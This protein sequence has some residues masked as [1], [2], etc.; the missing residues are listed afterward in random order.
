[1]VIYNYKK[2]K[3][4]KHLI[5]IL[6]M[7]ILALM[8]YSCQTD[9]VTN[10]DLNKPVTITKFSVG[11]AD[12]TINE[13]TKTIK[14]IVPDGSDVTKISPVVVLPQGAVITPAITSNMDFTAPI[15]FTIVNGDVY[16]KY[17][18]SVT[19]QFFIG[20]L[21]TASTVDGIT[22]DDEKAAAAWFLK[23]YE[24]G[25]YVS[26][27]DI[28]NAKVD[29]N[30]YRVLWWYYDTSKDLP[31]I[32]KDPVVLNSINTY[33]KNG[34]NLLLN[35]Y[36]CSYFWDLGRIQTNYPRGID[37]GA[38]FDNPDAWGIG[39]NI[40]SHN[41]T[42]HP[43]YN[44][45]TF[46]VDGDG[47]HWVPVIGPGWKENHNYVIVDIPN[48]VNLSPNNNEAVYDAFTTA[49]K[50][51]WLGVWSGIR[52]YWMAGVMELSPTT[53]YKGKAIF[54]GIGG[55]EFNQNLSGTIN[56]SG[57]N[58]FQSNIN[59]MTKNSLDYLSIKN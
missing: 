12:G 35:G 5:N 45:I 58:I 18:I 47:Y 51:K 7:S 24:N 3:M 49:N 20:F 36:A 17:T 39:A 42:N 52:D 14:I 41:M 28:K 22:D 37:T 57:V 13:K 10:L 44:G 16:S 23:N 46:N 48:A 31:A 50:I 38:G 8:N 6:M 4:K 29:V 15:E 43:I 9:Y 1:L 19:E 27:E 53:T 11:S 56:P 59:K 55:F 32:A 33:Y 34:K 40:G 54:I 25:E 21:G 26:F 30:K 2:V